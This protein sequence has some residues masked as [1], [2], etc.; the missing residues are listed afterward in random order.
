VLSNIAAKG[1]NESARVAAAGMLL[2]R[3]WGKAQQDTT[4]RAEITVIVRRLIQDDPKLIE[5]APIELDT[6]NE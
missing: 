2:D 6:S 4:T 3:G 5:H 1:S